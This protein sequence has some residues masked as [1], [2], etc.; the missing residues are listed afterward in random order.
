M[1][2]SRGLGFVTAGKERRCDA[3][4]RDGRGTLA[5]SKVGAAD[6]VGAQSEVD[7]AGM[8]DVVGVPGGGRPN[9][10]R[11]FSGEALDLVAA[12]TGTSRP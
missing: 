1:R 11:G 7:A 3:G 4:R 10:E 6:E 9:V 12:L 5:R 8:T 2:L